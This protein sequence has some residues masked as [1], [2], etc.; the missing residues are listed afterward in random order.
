[1][2]EK[3]IKKK[4][5]LTISSKKSFSTPTYTTSGNKKSVVIE[6]KVSGTRSARRFYGRND[7]VNKS[8]S[9][10]QNKTKSNN[11]LV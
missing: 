9:S 6:K 10:F 8:I 3:K 4:L 5:T 11:N 2:V 7:N 1:M